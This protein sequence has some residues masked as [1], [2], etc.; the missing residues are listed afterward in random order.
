MNTKHTLLRPLLALCFTSLLATSV[1]CGSAQNRK[2]DTL[3]KA[4][5][6]AEYHYKLATG[7]IYEKKPIASLKELQTSLQLDP[8]FAK[9]HYLTGFIYM[10]RR[11]HAE[12]LVHLKRAVAL[13][14]RLFEANNALG[15]TYMALKRW[16]DALVVL[17]KLLAD[18]LNP[19]PWLAHNNAG[20][21]HHKLDH[22]IQAV[23]HLEMAVFHNPKFCLGHYNLGLVLK[24][25]MRL[26]PARLHFE[27]AQRKC[28]RHAPTLLALGDTYERMDRRSDALAAYVQCQKLASGTMLAEHCRNREVGLR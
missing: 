12:A 1:G 2:G 21:S 10:G 14:P 8:D 6:Q 18:P 27:Q 13:E 5:K 15:A 22:Q 24:E 4:E 25:R 23:H 7:F 17:E 28:P 11:N 19:T 9:S 20:W 3:N 16:D 26:N